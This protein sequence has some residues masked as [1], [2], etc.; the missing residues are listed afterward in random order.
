MKNQPLGPKKPQWE[1][2]APL[3]GEGW[4]GA[5]QDYNTQ[6]E[7]RQPPEQEESKPLYDQKQQLATAHYLMDDIVMIAQ[8]LRKQYDPHE[9]SADFDRLLYDIQRI[10]QILEDALTGGGPASQGGAAYG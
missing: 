8:G 3:D 5:W 10:K 9:E 6:M 7:Q 2:Y 4:V 1:D